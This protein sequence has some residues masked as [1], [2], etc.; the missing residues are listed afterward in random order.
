[1]KLDEFSYSIL[2]YVHAG[3]GERINIGALV[4][5]PAQ[6]YIGAKFETR[7]DYLSRTFR[8]FDSREFRATIEEFCYHLRPLRNSY[9]KRIAQPP[10]LSPI[11]IEQSGLIGNLQTAEDVL[12]IIWPDNGLSYQYSLARYGITENA[13][14]EL[15]QTFQTFVGKQRLPSV[16]HRGLRRTDEDIWGEFSRF[17]P[18]SARSLIKP[19]RIVTPQIE[20]KLDHAYKNGHYNVFQPFTLDYSDAD[21]AQMKAA[22]WLGVGHALDN[23]PDLAQLFF[24]LGTPKN[25]SPEQRKTAT[26][27][28]NLLNQIPI[29]KEFI[30]DRDLEQFADVTI[31]Y[32]KLNGDLPEVV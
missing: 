3:Y 18:E 32:M 28:E 9:L 21:Y 14:D 29:K 16:T 6:S 23:N 11:D 13:E 22:R 24:L 8:G 15:E 19:H 25:N 20:V 26:K 27:V 4:C 5:C 1:M 10:L 31:S 30:Y 2:S 17:L 7:Y 12:R